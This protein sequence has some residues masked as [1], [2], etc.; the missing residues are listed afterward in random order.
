MKRFANHAEHHA[1]CCEAAWFAGRLSDARARR[2]WR[3]KR[4]P[5][6]LE[7]G[8]V[9]GVG[10]DVA[11]LTNLSRDHLS[12]HG[13]MQQY[14]K[15]KRRLVQST[16][17]Q[18]CRAELDDLFGAELAEQLQDKEVEVVGYGLSD[19]ALT[20]AERLGMRMVYGSELKMDAQG[21]QSASAFKLGGG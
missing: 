7:Q 11:L 19:A 8:R 18:I 14:A 4:L 17:T 16:A 6:A 2:Q 1:G 13:D 15:A 21:I 9:N 20:L 3:W 12:Y 10:Y 5:H